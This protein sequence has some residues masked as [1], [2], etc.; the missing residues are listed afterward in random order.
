MTQLPFALWAFGCLLAAGLTWALLSGP[1]AGQAFPLR[2]HIF[3]DTLIAGAA[4]EVFFALLFRARARC[5]GTGFGLPVLRHSAVQQG[6]WLE[7]ANEVDNKGAEATPYATPD[8]VQVDA[9]AAL[10]GC[11]GSGKKAGV[12]LVA[13]DDDHRMLM[14]FVIRSEGHVVVEAC[15]GLEAVNLVQA[16]PGQFACVVLDIVMPLMNGLEAC[17]R[18]KSLSPQTP[19]ILASAFSEQSLVGGL[20]C[21]PDVLRLQKPFGRDALLAAVRKTLEERVSA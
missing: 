19:V 18:I 20:G 21:R 13:D 17:E 11:G 7:V 16:N 5:A 6:G 15:N 8:P 9:S 1:L 3:R 14:G 2:R 4:T 10:A 12:I